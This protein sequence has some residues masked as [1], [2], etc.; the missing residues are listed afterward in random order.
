MSDF[1]S[2]DSVYRYDCSD[3]VSLNGDILK[4][5]DELF[6]KLLILP[7]ASYIY[8]SD[9]L[10]DAYSLLDESFSSLIILVPTNSVC[11]KNLM[12]FHKDFLH[13]LN[14]L[15]KI[16]FEKLDKLSSLYSVTEGDF[17]FEYKEI[18]KIHIDFIRALYPNIS[19][20]PVFYNEIDI[21]VVKTLL[22]SFW[23]D[24]SFVF[25]SNMSCGFSY[26]DAKKN[27]KFIANSIENLVERDY[28]AEDFTAYRIL[29]EL[30]GFVRLKGASF[31]RLGLLNSGDVGTNLMITKGFGAWFLYQGSCSKLVKKYFRQDIKDFILFNLSKV[32]NC[33]CSTCFRFP[34]LFDQEF[35]IFVSFEKNGF[36]RGVS[37]SY[38]TP[39]VLYKALVKRSF[40]AAFSDNRFSPLRLDELEE[41]KIF[42]TFVAENIMGSVS[43]EL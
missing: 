7:F 12:T 2:S 11:S 10:A 35:K 19:I 41:I 18:L 8:V 22:E 42:V 21:G 23:F 33:S 13:S 28:L 1:N 38:K 32:L 40:G 6:S 24:S 31:I 17:E 16:D 20:L 15:I 5:K 34:K 29:N 27:D 37:G 43:F 4:Y 3:N 30:I 39:E 26:S 25:L 36:V 9:M 14:E